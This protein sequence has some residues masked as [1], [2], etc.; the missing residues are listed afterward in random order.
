MVRPRWQR[1][2]G[3]G[4]SSLGWR[5]D[6]FVAIWASINLA[7]V[8]FDVTYVPLRN[9]WLQR[10]LYLFPGLPL[11]IPL[12]ALP[13]ITPLY[14]PVKGIEP[15][16]DTQRYLQ[17]WQLLDQ[18]LLA[19]PATHPASRRLLQQQLLL[20]QQLIDD[21]PFLGANK[22]GTLERIKN[23]L[24]QR[25]GLDS[26]RLGAEQLLAPAWLQSH[27]W[28]QE[29]LFWQGEV[30]PLVATNYWRSI[31]ETGRPT[32]RFWRL[33][34]LVF[35]SVFFVDIVLRLINLRR[36]LPG[37]SWRDALLR[38]WTDLP[39]LLPFWR[40]AR[41][42]PVAA[43]LRS[44]GLVDAEPVRAVVS[45]GVVALLAVELIE[46]LALQL[47]DG[48]QKLISSPDWS[49]RLR[50]NSTEN[51]ELEE[52]L[53]LW[54]PLLLGRVLP[55][56]EPELQALL[57]YALQR[58]LETSA[59]PQALQRLQPLLLLEREFTRQLAGGMVEGVLD[60]SRG[61]AQ[62]LSR[63]DRRGSDLVQQMGEA[64]WRELAAAMAAG[65]TLERSQKLLLDLLEELKR[66]YLSRINSAG[67]DDL[68]EELDQLSGGSPRRVSLTSEP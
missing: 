52:L 65:N 53:R 63:Q 21:N 37:L 62:Q 7:L 58:S 4:L 15:H 9:F 64:F 42:I 55:R 67:V 34:L 22:T 20:T 28:G 57:S 48:V 2:L 56:L 40:L 5:W 46:V 27:P 35:Q 44:S 31:D 16:R 24:R 10:H 19:Q 12:T 47:L 50:G 23:R 26:G 66:G 32:E 1:P 36:R 60:L 25:T 30:L 17:Q 45:R 18:Q 51:R 43:R 68:L 33:D 39:L 38:R 13:D 3:L 14:D 61:T 59:F 29:R 8:V 49:G 41:V 6:R 11:A 54:G